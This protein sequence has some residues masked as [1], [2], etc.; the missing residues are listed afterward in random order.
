LHGKR[1]CSVL[2]ERNNQPAIYDLYVSPLES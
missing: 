1:G 2:D